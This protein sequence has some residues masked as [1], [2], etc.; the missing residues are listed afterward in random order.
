MSFSTA[1][2][3]EAPVKAFE[4]PEFARIAKP[5]SSGSF[6]CSSAILLSQ[7][8]T[9]AERIA[10][11]EKTPANVLPGAI[12]ASMTSSRFLRCTA[13]SADANSTPPISGSS[14]NPP[15]GASGETGFGSFFNRKRCLRR[16][17]SL[18][19]SRISSLLIWTSAVQIRNMRLGAAV[20]PE[21]V[22]ASV[23]PA[24]ASRSPLNEL[25]FSL[26][27]KECRCIERLGVCRRPA[28]RAWFF[29]ARHKQRLV[30]GQRRGQ[31]GS[32]AAKASKQ[33][34]ALSAQMPAAATRR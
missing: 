22:N 7:S 30:P 6:H 9:G 11:R 2:T 20:R 25:K 4:F 15:F 13:A 5:S 3:P 12:L 8:K 23:E 26:E 21:K 18:L 29:A 1:L 14:G 19:S 33:P 16:L 34:F 32:E 31:A 24:Q 17:I 10:E 28:R 27:T